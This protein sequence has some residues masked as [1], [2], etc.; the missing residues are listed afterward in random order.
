MSY[1]LLVVSSSLGRQDLLGDLLSYFK[2]RGKAFFLATASRRLRRR[3]VHEHWPLGRPRTMWFIFRVWF[4]KPETILLVNWPEKIMYSLFPL[5]SK[6]FWLE[7][8]DSK[9]ELFSALL[10]KLYALASRRA[11]LIVFGASAAE[12]MKKLLGHDRIHVVPVASTHLSLQQDSIFKT[13]AVQRERGRFVVGAVLY[14]LPKVQAE[15]LLSALSIA[16][17]VCPIIELVIL[18][19]GKNRPQIQWLIR[20]M[21]LERKV[22]LAGPALDFS[23]WVNQFDV[24]VMANDKAS[25]S[26][27]AWA[28]SAMSVGLPIL[29]PQLDWLGDIVS[30]KAG[31]LIDVCDPETLAR[32]I[33][34]LQQD[35]DLCQKLGNE[36]RRLAPQFSFDRFAET[37]TKLLS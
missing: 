33:I 8:P 20:R 13:L 24:Y 34:K 25:L 7:Y 16:Q 32:Q 9:P 21:N 15:R 35:E 29:G 10:K 28:I 3:A 12:K 30:P 2:S 19:E 26:D 31:A 27:A 22:W 6:I 36:A 23:R 14:G 18:G 17:S 5:K 1:K 37:I 4:Q 11:E